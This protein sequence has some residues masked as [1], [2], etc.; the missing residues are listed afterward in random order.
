MDPILILNPHG[1]EGESGQYV[2]IDRSPYR[3]GRRP[4][5]D[6]Q[7]LR[8]DVSGLHAE[9]RHENDGWLLIDHGSTNGSFVNGNRIAHPATLRTGDLV[10]FGGAG[11]EILPDG[12]ANE[13]YLNTKVVPDH[14]SKIRSIVDLH[15]VISQRR[16]Y[17]VF[18]SI[19]E[20]RERR[21]VGWEALG[22][23]AT[24]DPIGPGILFELAEGNN[25]A[26]DLSRTFRH[27]AMHCVH[28]H[29]CWLDEPAY[30][31]LNLHP[32]EI[33]GPTFE[34]ILI[35]IQKSEA[36]R[37]YRIVV[38]IPESLVCKT[39]DMQIWV[40]RIRNHDLLV[41]YDDFG[42]GQSRIPDLIEVPPD[43]LKLDRDLIAGLPHNRV[44]NDLVKALVDA[45]SKLHVRTLGEGI[46]TEEEFEACLSM[47]IEFGQ[48][49]LLGRP[50]PAH[51]LFEEDR[52]TLPSDCPF[53][54]LGLL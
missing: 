33:L 41:A 13:D 23:A 37:Q 6:L 38:E 51:A 27:S 28:C 4:D 17:P 45:C 16:G 31:F 19:H 9:F 54:T 25:L 7:L 49:Y 52:S 15:R 47:G 43:F 53:L 3:V 2:V 11:Y 40:Q 12:E 32:A 20:L 34:S 46:E 1:G 8:P 18:Q 36:R 39:E 24:S 5:N 50:S 48:G 29:H 35:E 42:R 44:K 14:G 21:V 30:L 10:H 26:I 22:R